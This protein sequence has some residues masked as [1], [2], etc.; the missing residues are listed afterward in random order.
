MY[1]FT[2]DPSSPYSFM[3]GRPANGTGNPKAWNF[4][5]RKEVVVAVLMP[6]GAA[7]GAVRAIL[8]EPMVIAVGA[9]A[10]ST[11]AIIRLTDKRAAASRASR[12]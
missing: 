2:D 1:S 12:R 9:V 8:L 3:L 4:M 10:A 11:A 7:L 6:G 5:S